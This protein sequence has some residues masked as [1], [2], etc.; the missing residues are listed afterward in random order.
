MASSSF[1]EEAKPIAD[2]LDVS[3]IKEHKLC[4]SC[5]GRIFA[6]LG[7]GEKDDQ[8]MLNQTRGQEI[9][10]IMGLDDAPLP[11]DCWLC[12]GITDEHARFASLAVKKMG[13]W[14]YSTF[15][16]G[17][18][19]DAE[20]MEKEELLWSEMI[21]EYSEPIKAEFNREVG[22]LVLD[23]TEKN[24]EFNR[25]DIVA[26]ID[27][28][29]ESIAL[30]ISPLYLYGRYTKLVR[31]IPQTRWPCRECL[32]KGC[33]RCGNTGKMYQTSVEE[34]V[35][36][37]VMKHSGGKDH[38]FHGMGREDVDALMRGNGRPFVI[39]IK[40][41]KK[42]E[43]P[44]EQIML[45][46]EK[47]D[48]GVGVI[49]LRP[50]DNDEVVMI[51]NARPY[52]RYMLKATIE[53]EFSEEKLKEVVVS[54]GEKVIEQKTPTRVVHRRADKIRK[55]EVKSLAILELSGNTVVFDITAEAGTYVKE[56]V[57]GDEG[58]TQ[59]SIA[60]EMGVKIKVEEL[61]VLEILDSK[62]TG[63]D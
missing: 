7:R 56:L 61:D 8:G 29:Y 57:H 1:Q 14:E 42:R 16:I 60:G 30:Q 9:T 31:G 23:M 34:V 27:T 58:R 50:S 39:E 51:K 10:E 48:E 20:I 52:K 53:G 43:L 17:S 46:I 44:L 24:V 63:A 49:G 13:E 32:G 4:L 55:R 21:G 12:E 35:G 45:D 5:L 62:K 2:Q 59:P 18:K 40:E 3:F 36:C 28:M 6:K 19:F 25:P 47:S 11:T 37:H 15:L 38:R 26:V 33:E 41:P 54:L 22:K